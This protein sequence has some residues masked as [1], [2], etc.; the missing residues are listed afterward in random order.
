MKFSIVICSAA[1]A[2][3]PHTMRA[4]C[5]CATDLKNLFFFVTARTSFVSWR[6]PPP[7]ELP[8]SWSSSSSS[9]ASPTM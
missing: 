5:H 4:D 8:G 6:R 9:N 2:T 1:T 3:C 7:I